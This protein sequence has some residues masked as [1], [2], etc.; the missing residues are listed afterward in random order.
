MNYQE[1]VKPMTT[2]ELKTRIKST[3]SKQFKEAMETELKGRTD[4]TVVEHSESLQ[5]DVIDSTATVVPDVVETP[6]GESESVTEASAEEVV[7][8]A[9]KQTRKRTPRK[10]KTGE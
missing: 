10:A 4:S 7:S 3:G 5:E 9:P 8:E 6:T 2:G 1:I